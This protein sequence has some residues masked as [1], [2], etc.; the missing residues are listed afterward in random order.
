M[1]TRRQEDKFYQIINQLNEWKI[2]TVKF[3]LTF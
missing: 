2:T 1:S 3:Y